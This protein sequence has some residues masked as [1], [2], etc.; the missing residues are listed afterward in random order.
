VLSLDG[1]GDYVQV[2]DS[3]NLDITEQITLECW[4]LIRN[5]T[6]EDDCFVVKTWEE[7]VYPWSVYAITRTGGTRQVGFTITTEDGVQYAL[8]SV[9]EL[10]EVGKWI[11]LAGVYDGD[12]MLLYANGK[13]I[14]RLP[15]TERIVTNNIP[16]SI[17]MNNLGKREA[18]DA[19][20]D[21]VRIWNV[22]RTG[23]QIR[24][25]MLTKVRGDEPGLIA[26][27]RFEGEG[28]IVND[29]T[30]NG[31]DGQLFGDATR[32]I[33][34]LPDR[35]KLTTREEFYQC[36]LSSLKLE[37]SVQRKELKEL[38][39]ILSITAHRAPKSAVFTTPEIPVHIEI[40]DEA[41]KLLKTLKIRTE[42]TVDWAVPDDVQEE[43][44][45]IAQYT[46]AKRSTPEAEFTCPAHST[47][48]VTKKLG[49]WGTL[50]VTHGLSG[51]IVTSI[52]QDRNG[53][54]WF[55]LMTDGVCRYDGRRFTSFTKQ[56]GL[57]SNYIYKIY[58]DS[59]GNLWFATL[60][61][62]TWKGAGV[63]KY[64]GVN[65]QTY[66]TK[67]G[68]VDDAVTTIYEDNQGNLWFGTMNGV[69]EFDGANF[70][71]YTPE[72]GFPSH[73][74]VRELLG[75]D[76]SVFVGAITQDKQG[77]LWFGHG[78]RHWGFGYGATRYDG[79]SFKTLTTK[80]GLAGDGVSSIITDKQGNLWFGAYGG[81]SKYDGKTFQNFT[82]KEGL[83][84]K[85]VTDIFQA[86]N[87][88]LWFAT[89]GG[90]SRYQD[91]KFHSF[92]TKDGLAWNWVFCITEDREGNIWLGTY[93]EANRYDGSVT[94]IPMEIAFPSTPVMDMNENLWFGIADRLCQ[95]DGKNITTFGREDGFS[96][97]I[98]GPW[99]LCEDRKGNIWISG[100]GGLTK[101]DR[102]KFQT[103]TIKDGLSSNY[104]WNIYED[105]EGVLWLGTQWGGICTYDGEKFVQIAGKKELGEG[106][107]WITAETEDSRGNM[108]FSTGGHGVC[109][110][111]GEQFTFFTTENGLPNKNIY[112]IIEDRKGN[113][114][115]VSKGLFRY[116]GKDFKVF[117]TKDGLAENQV[118]PIFEDSKGNLWFSTNTGGV[119]KFDGGN[120]QT[121]TIQ[122]GFL[123]NM[124]LGILEDEIGNMIF[125]TAKGITIY[126]PS[127]EEIPPPVLVT[128]VVADKV[129]SE[130]GQAQLL[131][132]PS[133][134]KHVSFA[135]HGMSFKTRRMRYNYML[136][137]YDKDWQ[138]TWDE[139]ISYEN[140]Q[141]G[142]YT[143]KVI[144]INRD[145]VYSEAP[146]T[147]HLQIVTPFYLRASF[148]APIIGFGVILIATLTILS[149]GYLNRRREIQ[150]YQ[151]A[152]VEELQDA[153]QVQMGLMPD[154]PPAIEGVDIA[155]KCLPANDVSG[156]FFDY[157]ESKEPNEIA[158][159]VADV[160]GK[161][162][163][164]A[165]NAVMADG[166][167]RMA[168]KTQ[169][170]LSPASLMT[171]IN[172][173]LKGRMEWGMNITMVIAAIKRNRC[174]RSEAIP[175]NHVL[176]RS[177][178]SVSES[179]TT[180]I[181]ANAAH[182]AHPLL[183]RNGE[184]QILKTG[185]LPLGMRAGI[186]YTEEQLLLQSGDVLILMTDGI[187][188]AKACPRAKRRDSEAN[189]YSDSGRLEEIISQFTPDMPAEAMVDAIINDAI[190]YSGD[191]TQ[192]DDDMTVVVARIQ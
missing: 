69:S 19:L 100:W 163:K 62:S 155:G 160:C 141:P 144:A 103:F 96:F 63:C 13:L 52:L 50:G 174:E 68:L 59:D 159:V 99:N 94:N 127:E 17:G 130:L 98:G 32:V 9:A 152:A 2:P 104:V 33:S 55:G 156:D 72:D 149:L 116:D 135:Y 81:V 124:A 168:A 11:Y 39:D 93:C 191:K 64:D 102:E 23:E 165:M 82:T 110:Y 166:V 112:S 8:Y 192:R 150:A 106:W 75:D 126:S 125:V 10:L 22:A 161:A 162:M 46:D 123:Q 157:L 34:E 173:V 147:I 183:L 14:N 121:F 74:R 119:Q 185:G 70:R 170:Q 190:D 24:D 139:Q 44:K 86:R 76:C 67:D 167:L 146:A 109:K 138:A 66:T 35:S 71:N 182:H 186:Q 154:A 21:E 129:Y 60:R 108:W 134:A 189:D 177:E 158:L 90:V 53:F 117:T 120:F 29:V 178:G 145:L 28:E 56:D 54:L 3:E 184:I 180:L 128:E 92:T 45:I 176:E 40:R 88:D 83:C 7:D 6:S 41:K 101:Y 122:D 179:K 65:F 187:I 73:P 188:E 30:G 87:G 47:K 115:M 27:W 49:H 169:E 61:T 140:L 151:Q 80:D 42:E 175:K 91:G 38:K 142:D 78:N 4:V 148:L 131:Q 89:G 95:Y 132:I 85:G 58:Q 118:H 113:I 25:S 57:P 84:S 143:F 18:A 43:L 181:I 172:D 164:G 5:F 51:S 31:N 48:P 20:I 26:Y 114:W 97:S 136:E 36:Y 111:N 105:R 137:G 77:N 107:D 1:D 171:E 153:R 37:L 12:N 133:T 16:L 15:V 79:E